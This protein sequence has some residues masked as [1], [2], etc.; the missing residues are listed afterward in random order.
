LVRTSNESYRSPAGAAAAG[1][2]RLGAPGGG[3]ARDEVT[4]TEA[5]S[6]VVSTVPS[7]S[8]RATCDEWVRSLAIVAAFGWP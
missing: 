4:V 1:G 8:V 6:I 2:E 3:P 7:W 5:L